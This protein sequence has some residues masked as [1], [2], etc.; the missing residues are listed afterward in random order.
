MYIY[1]V[2]WSLSNAHWLCGYQKMAKEF[3]PFRN[4]CQT[5]PFFYLNSENNLSTYLKCEY[6]CMLVFLQWTSA[7]MVQKF[8]SR[9]LSQSSILSH[10]LF[11]FL[12]KKMKKKNM[13]FI[14]N[15]CNC[16]H[17]N[18][19]VTTLECA[20]LI[21]ISHVKSIRLC[22]NELYT[23][24]FLSVSSSF[25]VDILEAQDQMYQ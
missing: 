18:L 13:T 20:C 23:G 12:Q 14:L 10:V 7:Y 17:L 16:C 1:L 15:W 9:I 21:Y 25:Y 2:Y 3:Q 22:T 24:L 19:L 4:L 6:I 11:D 5:N 8:N